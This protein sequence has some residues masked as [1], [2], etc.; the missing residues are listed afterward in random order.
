MNPDPPA[1]KGPHLHRE[2][3]PRVLLLPDL[4]EGIQGCGRDPADHGGGGDSARTGALYGKARGDGGYLHDLGQPY[5]LLLHHLQK[6]LP[7]CGGEAGDHGEG[8]DGGRIGPRHGP[9]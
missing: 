2:G 8:A 9:A 6:G 4:Q 7:G 1:G 5:I 3:Q